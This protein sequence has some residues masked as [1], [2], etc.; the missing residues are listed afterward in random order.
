MDSPKDVVKEGYGVLLQKD[1]MTAGRFPHKGISR[2]TVSIY[3]PVT[4]YEVS[5]ARIGQKSS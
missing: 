5:L 3:S 4:W 2:R 1:R